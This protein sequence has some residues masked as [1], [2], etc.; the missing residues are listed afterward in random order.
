MFSHI[1]IK[2]AWPHVFGVLLMCVCV[3]P[4]LDFTA[5]IYCSQWKLWLWFLEQQTWSV[6]I[7]LTSSE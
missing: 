7:V 4:T 6:P 1:G 3:C 5:S 2:L